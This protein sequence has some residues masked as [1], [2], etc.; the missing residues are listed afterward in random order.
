MRAGQPVT[1][2]S[3]LYGDGVE[4]PRPRR[5]L[6]GGTGAAFSLIPAQNASGNWI[7][8]VQRLPVRITLDPGAASAPAARRP[9]DERHRRHLRRKPLSLTSMSRRSAPHQACRRLAGGGTVP[10]TAVALAL[11]TFMQVLDTTIA[12]V[13]IP[14]IAG[15]L[16]VSPTRAPGY[17]RFRG[18]QRR[19]RCR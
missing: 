4:L 8:V 11:G 6:S 14:T 12:N 18:G 1:L 10:I 2:T 7:K 3:D 13:S 5:G 9:V 16:G 15:N 17:H 19:F